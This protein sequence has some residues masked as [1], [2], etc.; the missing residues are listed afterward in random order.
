MYHHYQIILTLQKSI[1]SCQKTFYSL[2]ATE[3]IKK[4][5]SNFLLVSS[6][7]HRV[8]HSTTIYSTSLFIHYIHGTLFN[9][10]LTSDTYLFKIAW[11]NTS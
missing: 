11:N 4:F 3:S 2:K 7:S 9:Y 10:H 5:I 8:N 1:I 6:V